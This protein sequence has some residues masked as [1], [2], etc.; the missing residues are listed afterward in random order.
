MTRNWLQAASYLQDCASEKALAESL[1]M[2]RGCVLLVF[3]EERAAFLARLLASGLR[4]KAHQAL[5]NKRQLLTVEPIVMVHAGCNNQKHTHLTY[6]IEID[7]CGARR[8]AVLHINCCVGVKTI[9]AMMMHGY[10]IM[11]WLGYVHQSKGECCGQ[12]NSG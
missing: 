6:K 12:G 4:C 7:F 5:S 9:S 2:Q 10:L 8:L 11:C 3:F 1:K